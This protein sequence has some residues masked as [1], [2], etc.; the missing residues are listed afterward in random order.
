MTARPSRARR[1]AVAAALALGVVTIAACDGDA[2]FAPSLPS[3]AGY[4]DDAGALA[5]WTGTPC[6]GVTRVALTFTTTD[7]ERVRLV[8]RAQE[9]G[10]TVERLDLARPDPA[11]TVDEALPAGFDWRDAERISLLMDASEP[12]W[13]STVAVADVVDGSPDHGA[14]TY[15]FDDLGWKDQDDV[16]AENGSS[17]LT[18]CTPDPEK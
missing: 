1:L 17:F 5:I 2:P 7:D 16:R 8:L 3:A 14:G 15:L 11:F 18:L 6:T 4:R 10:V 13:S 9:P 12:S